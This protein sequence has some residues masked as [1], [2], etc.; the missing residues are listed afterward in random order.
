V[1]ATIEIIE[2]NFESEV[3]KSEQPLLAVTAQSTPI[4]EPHN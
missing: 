3:L 4:S 2:T 1:K